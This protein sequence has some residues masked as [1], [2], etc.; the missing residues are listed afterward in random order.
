MSAAILI[1]LWA[2][3]TPVRPSTKTSSTAEVVL[4]EAAA[5]VAQTV[6]PSATITRISPER[7]ERARARGEG[8]GRVV[9]QAAGAR[10]LDLGGPVG[11]QQLT[12]RGGAPT[13]ALVVVDGVPLRTPF[14]RGFDIGLVHPERLEEVEL[15]RGGQG[16]SWGDGALTGVLA[17]STRGEDAPSGY[18]ASLVVG[19]MSTARVS[20]SASAAGLSAAATYERT[21]GDFGYTSRLT[22][23]EDVER[24]REN[25]DAQRITFG[26][27]AGF[28]LAGGRLQLRGG[29]AYR[30]AGVPGFA[31]SPSES[32]VAR[33]QTWQG[34]LHAAWRRNLDWGDGAE[35]TLA[36]HGAVLDLAYQDPANDVATDLDF[37]SGGFD[38]ALN[39]G[40][41]AAHLLRFTLFA[42]GEGVS[43]PELPGRARFALGIGDEWTLSQVALFG[44]LRAEVV[45]GQRIAVL[46]RLGA[47]W[48]VTTELSLAVALGRSLRTPTLDELH[49]PVELAY[50][51]NPEL[52]SEQAWEAELSARLR[53]GP[54]DAQLATFVRRIERTILYLN[55]NAFLVR[56]ENVGGAR[57][58]GGELELSA[59]GQLG[60]IRLSGAGQ[61]SLLASELEETGARLPTQ[62]VWSTAVEG[63][64]GWG[65]VDLD[66]ALRAFGPTF[67]NLRPSPQNRVPAY[68]RWDLGARI[69]IGPH[70]ML[71]AEVQ[72]V[73]DRRTLASVNRFP[74]PGRTVFVSLR[75]RGY[76]DQGAR[77]ISK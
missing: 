57:A 23:L 33:E 18:A 44:A 21:A 38:G 73:L 41:G 65:P 12:L 50:S 15:V 68:L 76:E 56:P 13:Q 14:A 30:A 61:V 72:N 59:R 71:G 54:I 29:G 8:L 34:R 20:A 55:R 10:V 60:P 35:L 16:A 64:A 9:D 26:A 36:G 46:P 40:L 28:D 27:G 66:S 3:V 2:G 7:L 75:A 4:I 70:L 52:E 25:N 32:R 5:P 37:I 43:G 39:L 31:D 42:G 17:L 51:G 22:D 45:G 24:V 74:L 6:D 47:R 67:V 11:Q 58:A 63:V 1:V 77:S 49:H 53:W 62:P 19:S 69:V 48:F